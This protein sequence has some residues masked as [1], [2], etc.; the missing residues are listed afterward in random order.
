MTMLQ[1]NRSRLRT[2]IRAVVIV[3]CAL[4]AGS[5]CGSS[6]EQAAPSGQITLEARQVQV[7]HHPQGGQE[8]PMRQ[9]ETRT[10]SKG[11]AVNVD[12][13]GEAALHFA[14]GLD[15]RIFHD[16]QLS[17]VSEI[18]PSA[19]PIYRYRLEAGTTFNT[20]TPQ[21]VA[22]HRV[23]VVETQW[24]VITDT[25][26]TF[27]VYVDPVQATTW[28]VVTSGSVRVGAAGT[29]VTVQAGQQTVV[30]PRKPP[31]PPRPASRAATGNRFPPIDVLTNNALQDA[32][33]LASQSAASTALPQ[34]TT[35]STEGSTKVSTEAP[36]ETPTE[37]P[38]APPTVAAGTNIDI[39]SEGQV[40]ASSTYSAEF[41][42]QLAIDGKRTTSWFSTGP[43][44]GGTTTFRWTGARDDQITAVAILSN[45]DHTN[46]SF[47][48]N[49]GFGSVTIQVLDAADKVVFEE[50]V[51]LDGTPDPDVAVKPQVVG[52][53]V[54]L[55]LSG[56]ED[57]TCG[58][59]SEL[60][61]EARR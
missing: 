36:T 33:V 12:P 4:A 47:R 10:A 26:T 25:G 45:K 51:S 46:A 17:V 6:G 50:I 56:H 61:I 43:G 11:D 60:Q 5:G 54:L 18:N 35:S 13:K 57:R 20:L 39:T 30:E 42:A 14:D 37:A 38:T 40:Q 8:A 59:F 19:A 9:S 31:E 48:K 29:E 23:V 44:Q 32:Q 15:V 52:R 22:E 28:T 16:S 49:F 41:P 53:S 27:L 21:A 55:V 34:P 58:G 7:R 2:L 24:A 3:A 1:T